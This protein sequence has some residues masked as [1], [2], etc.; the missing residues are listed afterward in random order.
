MLLR[1]EK[2]DGTTQTRSGVGPCRVQSS[3]CRSEFDFRLTGTA[4]RQCFPL[5]PNCSN[6]RLCFCVLSDSHKL[7]RAANLNNTDML[8][9]LL[10]TGVSP[11]CRDYRRRTPLHLAASK[12]YAKAVGYVHVLHVNLLLTVPMHRSI[13]CILSMIV[14]C[15]W[16]T[17]PIRTS[18][19]RWVTSRCIWPPAPITWT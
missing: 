15:S 11:N 1:L 14:D 17:A 10:D 7:C 18:K 12:G 9:Q 4:S 8:K 16:R 6:R 2:K 19:T 3:R 13:T 5:P